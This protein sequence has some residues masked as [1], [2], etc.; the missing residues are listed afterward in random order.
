MYSESLIKEEQEVIFE[1]VLSNGEKVY[2]M[3][4]HELPIDYYK[5]LI[6]LRKTFYDEKSLYF[7]K[8]DTFIKMYLDFNNFNRS[9]KKINVYSVS[10]NQ[11]DQ[12]NYHWN[13]FHPRNSP[14]YI[15]VNPNYEK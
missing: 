6:L 10:V 7:H 8:K 12:D 11:V 15:Y 9:T 2:N 3:P 1:M 4:L 13:H 5:G 14:L